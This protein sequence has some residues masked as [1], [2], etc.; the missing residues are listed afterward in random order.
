MSRKNPTW[1]TNL[2]VVVGAVCTFAMAD[3][4][5]QR[6]AP[7]VWRKQVADG[8]AELER[9]KPRILSLS[10]SHGRS[11]DVIMRHL[12]QRTREPGRMQSIS[13]EGGKAT[14]FQFVLDERLRAILE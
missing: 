8:V 7:R 13:M 6:I 14:H 11:M 4:G 3:A 10:S 12:L 2:L 5:L 9:G 1:K